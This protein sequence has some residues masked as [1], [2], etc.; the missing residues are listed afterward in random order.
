MKDPRMDL[1]KRNIFFLLFFMVTLA[2]V[3]LQVVHLDLRQMTQVIYYNGDI[4]T[5]VQ[6]FIKLAEIFEQI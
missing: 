5:F 1:K 3:Y 4:F 6:I 2:A